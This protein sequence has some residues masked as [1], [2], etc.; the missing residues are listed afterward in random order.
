MKRIEL[1]LTL[2][3][4]LAVGCAG[5]P[6]GPD[7]G[8]RRSG[9][10]RVALTFTHR[11]EATHFD[12]Q[13]H[14]VRLRGGSDPWVTAVLGIPDDQAIPLE[15]CQLVDGAERIDRAVHD[16]NGVALELLDA[17]RLVVKGPHGSTALQAWHYPQLTPYAA[18]V[19]YGVDEARGVTLEPG[20]TYTVVGDGGEE[21]GPFVTQVPAPRG[22]ASPE[23]SPL[24]LG[25]DLELRWSSV[26]V[27]DLEPAVIAL[28]WSDERESREVRCRVRDDGYFRLPRELI[29]AGQPRRAEV[30]LSRFRR[31]PLTAQGATPGELVV[32]L[33]DVLPL[34][35][36]DAGDGR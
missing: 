17:G 32:E 3:A 27:G 18:G 12:A 36:G 22:F 16:A 15:G 20:A 10:V 9:L 19:V 31:A 2:L 35:A 21:V 14:F 13:G 6:Q 30:A 8:D 28:A 11:G 33:R 4:T 5:R 26:G 34:A 1:P 24:T 7:A 29:P 25:R 23:A